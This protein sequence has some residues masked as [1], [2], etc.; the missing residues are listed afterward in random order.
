MRIN[1]NIGIR[2]FSLQLAMFE[3]LAQTKHYSNTENV[4]GST[5]FWR[6]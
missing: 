6:N 1:Y 3:T 2:V 5:L 4:S